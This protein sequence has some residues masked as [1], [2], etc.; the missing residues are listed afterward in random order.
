MVEV[1]TLTTFWY[2]IGTKNKTQTHHISCPSAPVPPHSVLAVL[3][4]GSDSCRAHSPTPQS[5]GGTVPGWWI[6]SGSLWSS[7]ASSLSVDERSSGHSSLLREALDTTTASM[8][9]CHRNVYTHAPMLTC[10]K[11]TRVPTWQEKPPLPTIQRTETVWFWVPIWSPPPKSSQNR[12]Y[13]N[14]LICLVTN[15]QQ[16]KTEREQEAGRQRGSAERPTCYLL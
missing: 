9:K 10:L 8:A 4:A 3:L 5:E 11:L 2:W 13:F 16:R 15:R 14:S 1:L 7:W 6:S 12:R